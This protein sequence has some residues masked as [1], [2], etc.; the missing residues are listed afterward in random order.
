VASL[1]FTVVGKSEAR[2]GQSLQPWPGLSQRKQWPACWRSERLAAGT[3]LGNRGSSI[4]RLVLVDV[5]RFGRRVATAG[6]FLGLAVVGAEGAALRIATLYRL[7]QHC[8]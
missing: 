5:D 7:T 6:A 1:T 8:E 4:A 3:C 2:C